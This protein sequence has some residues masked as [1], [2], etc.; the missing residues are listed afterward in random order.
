ME[1]KMSCTLH[2]TDGGWEILTTSWTAGSKDGKSTS[3]RYTWGP[4]VGGINTAQK[5]LAIPFK[6]F[7]LYVQECESAVHMADLLDDNLPSIIWHYGQHS[8]RP[9]PGWQPPPQPR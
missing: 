8:V 4:Q 2:F 3:L 5:D 1:N 9:H 6:T 7:L